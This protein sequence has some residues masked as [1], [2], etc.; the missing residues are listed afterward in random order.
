[1]PLVAQLCYAQANQFRDYGTPLARLSIQLGRNPMIRRL[2]KH[3]QP[4]MSEA[5]MV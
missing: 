4:Y 1:M 3:E 5:I 2:G